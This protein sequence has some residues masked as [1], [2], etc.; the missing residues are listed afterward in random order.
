MNQKRS[1][2]SNLSSQQTEKDTAAK[3]K[4]QVESTK[5]FSAIALSNNHQTFIRLTYCSNL[6][7]CGGDIYPGHILI[8]VFFGED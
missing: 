4:N 3:E 5:L 6:C 8:R 1:H 7:G 2:N